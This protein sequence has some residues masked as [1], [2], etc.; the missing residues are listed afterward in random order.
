MTAE[1][2]NLREL[3][4]RA[5]YVLFDFDGP[6]CRLFAGYS[7]TLIA[8]E[9][10]KWLDS[11]G[12]KGLL[13]EE[14]R[15]ALDPH[16]PLHAVNRRHPG[17]DL[18]VGLEKW[19]TEQELKAVPTAWPT[20]YADA[21]IRTW[22]AVGARLAVTTN[23][24][25]RAATRYLSSRGLT[26]CFGPYVYGRTQNLHWMKPD[27]H[28]LHHALNAMGADPS[29]SLMVGDSPPDYLAAREAGIP[30]LG[31]ARNERKLKE[32]V[33]A[34]AAEWCIVGSLKPVLDHLWDQA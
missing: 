25:P 22:N 33:D 29:T 3:I 30:F 15:T 11:H 26:E 16:V 14:E 12:L 7:A 2:E 5:R 24:S 19:L 31:F 4:T 32:L 17:S 28:W 6:I 9:L 27:P 34:G 18:V 8:E 10:V 20:E 21:L 23:N 13:T 1:T